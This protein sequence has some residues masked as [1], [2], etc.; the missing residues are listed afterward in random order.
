M[1]ITNLLIFLTFPDSHYCLS[2]TD[3]QSLATLI[4]KVF[5]LILTFIPTS[6]RDKRRFIFQQ[7]FTLC[8]LVY[9]FRN[10]SVSHSNKQMMMYKTKSKQTRP[11][12]AI[13]LCSCSL[14]NICRSPSWFWSRVACPLLVP[15]GDDV[16][17][18]Y[19]F[20]WRLGLFISLD[21]RLGQSDRIVRQWRQVIY[22]TSVH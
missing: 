1:H 22:T 2:L 19:C 21:T 11:A 17:P 14:R 16:M 7:L 3:L 8:V 18:N 4:L 6:V 9:F 20:H 10:S 13:L 12:F 15:V 5:F